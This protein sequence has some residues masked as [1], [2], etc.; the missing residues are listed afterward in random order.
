MLMYIRAYTS[1]TSVVG[2]A[3]FNDLSPSNRG[4]KSEFV[5]GIFL[6]RAL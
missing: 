5:V 3:D 2:G 4:K 1:R 6:K